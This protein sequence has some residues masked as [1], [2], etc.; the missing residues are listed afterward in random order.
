LPYYLHLL[1]KVEG[2]AHFDV[3]ESQAKAIMARLL[4]ELPGFLIPKLVREIG[5]QPSK[6]PIY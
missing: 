5:G 1:D 3:E 2:A 4:I 6:T